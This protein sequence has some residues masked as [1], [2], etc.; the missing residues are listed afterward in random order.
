MVFQGGHASGEF[1]EH[2]Q[3][4]DDFERSNRGVLIVMKKG[5]CDRAC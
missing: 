4:V 3:F 2:E 5:C 1:F